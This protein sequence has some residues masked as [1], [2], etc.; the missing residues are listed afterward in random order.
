V[1]P[2]AWS[3]ASLHGGCGCLVVD[4]SDLA[5]TGPWG[6]VVAII[7]NLVSFGLALQVSVRNDSGKGGPMADIT[8]WLSALAGNVGAGM[9]ATIL[10]SG[11]PDTSAVI[12]DSCHLRRRLIWM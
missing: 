7:L 8:D 11:F 5:S 9:V 1:R 2:S 6:I 4:F 10:L 12:A 3:Y